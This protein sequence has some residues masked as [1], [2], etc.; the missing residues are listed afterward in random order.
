MKA[1]DWDE[2]EMTS[3]H[4]QRNWLN[5]LVK[6]RI[7]I[8]SCLLAI[9][10]AITRLTTTRVSERHFL[11]AVLA[12][13]AASALW[14]VLFWAWRRDQ[15]QAKIQVIADLGFATAVLYYSGGVDTSFNFLFPLL[16]I[17]SSVLLSRVWAYSVALLA[18]VL[19]GAVVE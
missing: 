1:E 4:N 15:A 3:N 2:R 10:L 13:Y 16:I 8:I 19:F 7:L 14:L 6:A 5:W 11:G 17:V 12:W 18:S 9:E